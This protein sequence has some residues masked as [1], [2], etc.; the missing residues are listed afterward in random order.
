MTMWSVE[1]SGVTAASP[2][3]I[4]SF[5]E[6]TA[7]APKWDPLVAEIRPDGPLALGRTAHNKPLRGPAVPTTISELTAHV[8]Y[9][10]TVHLPGAAMAWTHRLAPN[11]TSLTITHGVRCTGPLAGVYRLLYRRK[12][13]AGMRI[14]LDN[15]IARAEA[16]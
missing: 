3:R 14:A 13:A 5:Y 4:W 1:V 8:S 7:T 15:L 6:D 9:T 11:Q 16:D 2:Q 12:F 10:E